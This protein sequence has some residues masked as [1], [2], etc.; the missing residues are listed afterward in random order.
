VKALALAGYVEPF[1]LRALAAVR[2]DQLRDE[3][4]A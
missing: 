3:A 2:S 1:A 4:A